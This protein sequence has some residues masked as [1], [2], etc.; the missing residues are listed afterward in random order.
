MTS[1]HNLIQNLKAVLETGLFS[2][3]V[4]QSVV[5]C[6]GRESPKKQQVLDA[7]LKRGKF[8]NTDDL[9]VIEKEMMAYFE[10]YK[11]A[12]YFNDCSSDAYFRLLDISDSPESRVVVIGDIHC[13]YNSLTALLLKLS[14]SDYDYFEKARFV[15]MGD[16]LDRGAAMF[17]PLLLLMDL[18][19]ILGDRMIMLRG[20]HE[21]IG[22]NEETKELESQVIPQDS[23]P[24]LNEFCGENKEFLQAF[25]YFYKT[26]PTYVYLKVAGQ[27]I[28]LTH[29]SV[30][31]QLFLDKF[32]YDQ[33]TGAIVFDL[34]F[35]YEQKNQ[36]QEKTED[37]SLKTM[38]TILD[39]SLLKMRNRILYDM[40]WGDPSSDR[41]KYQVSGRFQFGSSQFE[42]YVQKNHISRL[43]RSHEPVKDGYQSFFDDRL[44]TIFSTGGDQ[45]EQA[46]YGNINPAFAVVQ[47]DG[48]YFIENSYIYQA[49]LSGILNVVCNPF[50]G[51]LL[52]IKAG[53]RCTVN[54]EF[55]CAET[56]LLQIESIFAQVKE[57]F[58]FSEEPEEEPPVEEVPGPEPEPEAPADPEPDKTPEPEPGEEENP[59]Q[60][61]D[62]EVKEESKTENQE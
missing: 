47:G 5:A 22:Y 7:V 34:R 1:N 61:D 11:N 46:G 28:L 44:Y 6:G 55:V 39:E 29:A 23:C 10:E 9:P 38:T 8:V 37:D 4:P 3:D 42:A 48:R 32:S 41:E 26:L 40:I 62:R 15:F 16:Y 27:N 24:I 21:L 33:E 31:R 51:D 13:D 58:T 53:M 45:N 50:S 35:L 20:N 14:V 43:F 52:G 12:D 19:R 18:Q 60:E 30:P 56:T 2:K 59:K 36:A 49:E 17:E 57:G 25:G 54:E